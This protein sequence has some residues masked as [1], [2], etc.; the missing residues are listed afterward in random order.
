MDH[1][2][3]DDI[4]GRKLGEEQQF[5]FDENQW[6]T[7]EAQLDEK[8]KRRGIIWW[9]WGAA[10]AAI[11]LIGFSVNS[12]FLQQRIN[13]LE[14]QVNN[15]QNENSSSKIENEFTAFENIEETNTEI[16]L[17]ETTNINVEPSGKNDSKSNNVSAP[18]KAPQLTP[19]INPTEKLS[20]PILIEPSK[21]KVESSEVVIPIATN[22]TL[23]TQPEIKNNYA[24]KNNAEELANVELKEESELVDQSIDW[25]VFKTLD[26]KS[27]NIVANN[28]ALNFN[29]IPTDIKN[30]FGVKSIATGFSSQLGWGVKNIT[31]GF[32]NDLGR[33]ND[34]LVAEPVVSQTNYIQGSNNIFNLKWWS[35]LEFTKGISLRSELGWKRIVVTSLSPEPAAISQDMTIDNSNVFVNEIAFNQSSTGTIE[36]TELVLGA[37]VI[38]TPFRKWKVQPYVALI[39][40]FTWNASRTEVFT[41][42]QNSTYTP[43]EK[44][45]FDFQTR[46]FHVRNLSTRFGVQGEL[47]SK[48]AWHVEFGS[49]L[50]INAINPLLLNRNQIGIGIGYRFYR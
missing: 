10:T 49:N 1:K 25:S 35:Q 2:E 44:A 39:P 24:P 30:K 12:I 37:G 18:Q 28:T 14:S 48:L 29:P 9:Y 36:Q 20:Q 15:Y 42:D 22:N 21:N 46:K 40:E 32:L 31:S 16:E 3:F 17:T 34:L 19:K 5:P 13:Q 27:E 41:F 11:L 45:S 4:V 6:N 50:P 23:D 8:K 43:D 33:E 7:L 38:Y 26:N 47:W